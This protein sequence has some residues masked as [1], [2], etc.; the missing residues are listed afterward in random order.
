[1]PSISVGKENSASIDIYYEDHGSG[2]PVVLIHGFPLS[3]RS[4]ERQV[5]VLVDSGRRVVAYDRRGFGGSSQPATGYDYDTFTADLDKL[6]TAL[7]LRDATLVGFSMGTGEVARYLG[8]Y[9][10]DRVGRAV[11]ISSIPPFLLKTPDNPQGVDQ[12]VF[13]GIMAAIRKDR[14]AYLTAF[15]ES[16]YNLDVFLGERIGEEVVRDSWNVAAGASP[17]GTL[18][19]VPTWLTD[20]RPDVAKIDVPTLVIHGDADRILPISATGGPH[21]QKAIAGSKLTVIPGAPHGLLWTHAEEVNAALL[22]FL[23]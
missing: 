23:D 1:M 18:Q 16:F 2:Q 19:C 11:F 14:F 7:D 13:D 21:L 4:W 12:S 3:G 9:G 20:F 15:Y 22:G 8:T 10:S 17:I 6:M 5:A